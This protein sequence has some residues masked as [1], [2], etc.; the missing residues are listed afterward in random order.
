[1]VAA[2][3]HRQPQLA[4][5]R[6]MQ[7]LAPGLLL[8]ARALAGALLGR[9]LAA[10]P[11]PVQLQLGAAGGGGSEGWWCGVGVEPSWRA[12]AT[13][14]GPAAWRSRQARTRHASTP[15]AAGQSRKH[16]LPPLPPPCR[17]QSSL[18]GLEVE[19][20]GVV[21]DGVGRVPLHQPLAHQ[22]PA[23]HLAPRPQ[24]VACSGRWAAGWGFAGGVGVQRVGQGT[25][26]L[27]ATRQ[28]GLQGIQASCRCLQGERMLRGHGTAAASKLALQRLPKALLMGR[29]RPYRQRPTSAPMWV[30]KMRARICSK[31]SSSAASGAAAAAAA[32]GGVGAAAAAAA[33]CLHP[34]AAAAGLLRAVCT[35]AGAR[36]RRE[37]RVEAA[38][39]CCAALGSSSRVS[40]C[41][42]LST[43][44][45]LPR[46]RRS[47]MAGAVCG[48]GAGRAGA[49][50]REGGRR[51][52]EQCLD[53]AAITVTRPG[54]AIGPWRRTWDAWSLGRHFRACWIAT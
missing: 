50:V 27:T 39:T 48:P 37:V 22:R 28:M 18:L 23:Q 54:A 16:G 2:R 41:N 21:L 12:P 1:M 31:L 32:A 26:R 19:H 34:A 13:G 20:E 52:A 29:S 46:E 49:G 44:P 40:R 24:P 14:A 8:L 7:R 47:A 38:P 10:A 3:V 35:A 42:P 33:Y 15:P 25:R 6:T 36:Q 51:L 30:P 4:C 43:P 5:H 9:R 11:Q 53:K 45:R 17:P